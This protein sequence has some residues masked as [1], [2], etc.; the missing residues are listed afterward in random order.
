MQTHTAAAA[1]A[2]PT[3]M[4]L[5]E[6]AIATAAADPAA[7]SAAA[8]LAALPQPTVVAPS[9]PMQLAQCCPALSKLKLRLRTAPVVCALLC[10]GAL[11]QHAAATARQT[12]Y[13][14]PAC[15]RCGR[16][17][18]R[19]KHHRA[20]GS[21]RVCHPRCKPL[22]RAE[23]VA[24]AA[25]AAAVAT[26]AAAAAAHTAKQSRKRRAQSDPGESPPAQRTRT[27]PPA[28]TRR[29]SPPKP[30]PEKE[31]RRITRE[32]ARVSRLLDETVA[33]REAWL[34]AHGLQ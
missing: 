20:H 2:E 32:E 33:R 29:V 14:E 26:P 13:G 1:P 27:L 19:I 21:G 6:S 30:A 9:G 11:L 23:S 10:I 5:V 34:A 8:V 3:S 31:E 17:L 25:A 15:E 18:A 28:L 16:Q 12:A 7:A 24:G 22:A 4:E